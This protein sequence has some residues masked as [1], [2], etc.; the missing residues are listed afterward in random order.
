MHIAEGIVPLSVTAPLTVV[1]V[2]G[3]AKGLRAIDAEHLPTC[4]LF[5]AVFF[6][7]SLIHVPL[8]PTSTHLV[9]SGLIG[10]MLGWA[11]FPAILVGL[12]LQAVFFGFGGLLVLGVNTLTMAAPAVLAWALFR[13][14]A[15]RLAPSRAPVLAGICGGLAVLVSALLVAGVLAL[16]DQAFLPAAGLVVLGNLPVI[17]LESLITGAAVALLHRVRPEMLPRL[18]GRPWSGSFVS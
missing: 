4:G 13:G 11:A 8:G 14:L 17:G 12:A 15:D 5:S 2:A 7:A 18:G 16:S 6:V 9:L 3:V 10:L 1:A